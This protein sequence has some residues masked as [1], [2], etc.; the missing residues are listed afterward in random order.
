MVEFTFL[1]IHRLQE[2]TFFLKKNKQTN[3]QTNDDNRHRD[4]SKNYCEKMIANTMILQTVVTSESNNRHNR[5]FH[6]LHFGSLQF[7]TAEHP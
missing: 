1:P 7:V 4:A 5:S 6:D 2:K 3:K